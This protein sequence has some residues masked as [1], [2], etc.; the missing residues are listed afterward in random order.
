[1]TQPIRDLSAADLCV[2]E[3][4]GSKYDGVVE[5]WALS[6]LARA[7]KAAFSGKLEFD[8]FKAR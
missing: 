2:E 3:L 6:E 8:F 5:H 1:V 7:L 4:V